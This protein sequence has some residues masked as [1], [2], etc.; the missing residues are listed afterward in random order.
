MELGLEMN[1]LAVTANVASSIVTCSVV[2]D[3]AAA[4]E[5]LRRKGMLD[6]R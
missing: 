3:S 6:C 1:A 2:A 5:A 4:M